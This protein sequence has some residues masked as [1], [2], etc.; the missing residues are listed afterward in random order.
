MLDDVGA[1][2]VDRALVQMKMV[3]LPDDVSVEESEIDQAASD[4]NAANP[5]D[6]Q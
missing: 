5:V 1:P 4:E 2:T 3:D 6:E